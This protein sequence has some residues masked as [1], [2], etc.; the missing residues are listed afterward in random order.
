MNELIIIFLMICFYPWFSKG[1]KNLIVDLVTLI[2]LPIK[3]V[4]I[5]LDYFLNKI[6]G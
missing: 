6:Y 2:C 5:V 3:G 4:R 1:L